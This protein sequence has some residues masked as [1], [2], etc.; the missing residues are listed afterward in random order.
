VPASLTLNDTDDA[1][2]L[3]EV[4]EFFGG[5]GWFDLHMARLQA[6]LGY[7]SPWSRLIDAGLVGVFIL[8]HHF[9]DATFSERLMRAIWPVLWLLPAIGGVAAIAWRMA[10]REAG[11]MVLL[12]AVIGLPAMQQFKPGRID[13]HDVQIAIAVLTV[14]ATTWSDRSR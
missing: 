12:F 13:H 11:I 4:Q 5:D 2:R 6:P 1:M 7:D 3:V 10:G 8:F 14:A 9:A